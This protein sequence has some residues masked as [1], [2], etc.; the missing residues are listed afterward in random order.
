LL[1]ASSGR[2]G[3]PGRHNVRLARAW[4][5]RIFIAPAV[6]DGTACGCAL[7]LLPPTTKCH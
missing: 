5:G 7:S 6:V 4:L 1:P 3:R 2:C